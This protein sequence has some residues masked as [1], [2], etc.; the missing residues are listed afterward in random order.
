M[1]YDGLNIETS[2][3][4]VNGL[5]VTGFSGVGISISGTGSQGNWLWG[6]FVGAMPDPT[7]GRY[8]TVLDPA[9]LSNSVAGVE[10]TSSNNRVGGNTPGAFCVIANNGYDASGNSVGGVGLLITGQ[11]GTGNII[12]GNGI[13]SNAAQGILLESS[14]NTI[15]EALA[16]GG[17]SIAGNGADGVLITGGPDVQ[18]NGLLG[19]YIGTMFGTVDNLITLGQAADPNHGNGVLIDNSPNNYVGSELAA[20]KNII[21]SNDLDGIDITGAAAYNN[22]VLNDWIG[23]NIVNGLESFLPNQNGLDISA[24][25]RSSATASTASATSLTTTASTASCCPAR[26]PREP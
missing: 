16:G 23:F 9:G 15:G 5:V 20:S 3:C 4:I 26:I 10:I 25:G 2:N 12:E 11:G 17:N 13:F 22:L 24:P 18:G 8:F 19:N 6:D 1:G 7:N 21:G 14:N